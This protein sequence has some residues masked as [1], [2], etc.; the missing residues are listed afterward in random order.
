MSK[1]CWQSCQLFSVEVDNSNSSFKSVLQG[2][3]DGAIGKVAVFVWRRLFVARTQT[4]MSL[5]LYLDGR[6]VLRWWKCV[7]ELFYMEKGGSGKNNGKMNHCVPDF[8][9]QMDDDLEFSIPVS[10]KPST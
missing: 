8:E 4:N 3:Y 10:K 2:N 1:Y 6:G 9:T 7:D 5:I